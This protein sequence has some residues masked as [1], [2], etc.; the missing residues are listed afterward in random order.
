MVAVA[1]AACCVLCVVCSMPRVACWLLCVVCCYVL[2][3]VG[4]LLF[5]V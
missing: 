1:L 4:G 2:F 3:V 5:V